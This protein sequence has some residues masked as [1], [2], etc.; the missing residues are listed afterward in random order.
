MSTTALLYINIM[1]NKDSGREQV[2]AGTMGRSRHINTLH[3]PSRSVTSSK[4]NKHRFVD[5]AQPSYF[6]V[7][8]Q[9]I[10][11]LPNMEMPSCWS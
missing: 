1:C 5:L 7:K 6:T 11:D 4:N 8:L 3:P 9:V 2:R 10:F